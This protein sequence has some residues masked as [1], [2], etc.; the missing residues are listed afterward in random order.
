M[1]KKIEYIKG[2][3]IGNCIYLDDE[4]I[5]YEGIDKHMILN[6]HRKGRDITKDMRFLVNKN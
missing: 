3:Q 2:Q 4:G 1:S 5:K 6:R